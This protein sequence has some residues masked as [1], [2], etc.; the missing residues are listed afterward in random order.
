MTIKI[1]TR[2]SKL[3]MAQTYMVEKAIK[4]SY[5]AVNT[6]IVPII[7]KGDKIIDKPLSNFGGK[8]V[9]VSEIEQAL[10]NKEIDIA[11]HSAKDLPVNLADG[12][13]VSSVLPRGDSRDVLVTVKG[14]RLENKTNM[15]VGT[16]SLRRKLNLSKI[17]PNVTFADIRGNIDT[18]LNKLLSGNYNAIVL[19]YAGIER[20]GL[21]QSEK[22]DFLPLSK[23]VCIPAICQGIIA[24]ESRKDWQI[25][26]N[27]I[28]D[29]NTFFSFETERRILQ[30]ANGDCSMPVSAYSEIIDDKIEL[31]VT[32]DC[33]NFVTG[34]SDI[35]QRISLAERLVNML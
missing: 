17:Y 11:V 13:T 22:F 30:L 1:G 9:F 12:L 26:L 31:T 16:G 6:K 8:G 4:F 15:K 21:L 32:K 27:K 2:N 28:N 18:R 35:S 23:K 33:V 19:A 3:A 7:T 10:L 25:N 5:P 29:I 14:D 34:S 24:V 20:L